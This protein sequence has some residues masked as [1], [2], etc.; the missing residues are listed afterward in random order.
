MEHLG[1]APFGIEE[2]KGM[3]YPAPLEGDQKLA[4]IK[5]GQGSG[6]CRI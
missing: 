6:T 3:I 1:G 5:R 4:A 2:I